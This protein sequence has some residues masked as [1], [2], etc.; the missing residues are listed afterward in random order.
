MFKYDEP[1][2]RRPDTPGR[3]RPAATTPAF[4]LTYLIRLLLRRAVWIIG[5]ALACAVIAV[6]IGKS[7]TP[8]FAATTQL[9]IDPREL[10]LV[11]RELTPR[12]Q[13]LSG[14]TMV[15][16]S[17][18]RLM[19]SS[20]VLRKV[21]DDMKLRDDPEFG[22]G[23][24]L[25]FLSRL[26]GSNT[27]ARTLEIDEQAA[28]I[29]ALRRHIA[30]KRTDR[31]FIVDIEV[32]SRDATK[33]ALLA[34]AVAD[35]Y[36]I[37]SKESQAA[38]ARRATIDLSGRLKELQ[39]RL[40][41][42]ENNLAVYKS[43]N[44]FI[45]SQ[46][47]QVSDQQLLSGAQRLANA[48]AALLDAKARYSQIEASRKNA[49]D[50]GAIPEAMMSPTIAN[51]RTQFAE[52]RRKQAELIGELGPLH[53]A[54]R[55][56]N[57]Q[58]DDLRVNIGEELA[59]FAQLAKNDITRAQDL[60]TSLTKALDAQKRQSS[61]L[62]QAS[63]E[64]RELEREVE[65][66]RAIYQ[67]FLK[68]SRET[69]EQE[70]LNT[71]NARIIGAATTPQR[72]IFPPPMSLLA[73]IG[74]TL[75]ALGAMACI[76]LLDRFAW[77]LAPLPTMGPPRGPD[78]GRKAKAEPVSVVQAPPSQPKPQPL[79]QHQPRPMPAPV[80]QLCEPVYVRLQE[81]DVLR[82]LN[83]IFPLSGG[84]DIVRLGW[85][86][87]LTGPAS[88]RFADASLRMVRLAAGH[89][90]NGPV[91]I[92]ATGPGRDDRT[93]VA[94]NVALAATRTGWRVLLIDADRSAQAI[95]KRLN[96]RVGRSGMP[97]GERAHMPAVDEMS[98]VAIQRLDLVR[99]EDA[100]L[101]ALAAA[102]RSGL[103]DLIVLDG[104][105]GP[106]GAADRRLLDAIDG[107]FVVV[108]DRVPPKDYVQA[109]T[110]GLDGG[111]Q[112]LVG[113]VFSELGAQQAPAAQ[114][115]YA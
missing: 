101:D 97:G 86:T 59:R 24:T 40:R 10:Q 57:K 19:T 26:F 44:N 60:E 15:A 32:W 98:G 114:R 21:V 41:V 102:R 13:D 108:P 50:P 107:V 30:V 53:P 45:G 34:N 3:D 28:A 99:F 16:E 72:R 22:G 14:L 77:L 54:L 62:G 96:S 70:S 31:T 94:L 58:V 83:G 95:S 35:A 105:N 82:T 6:V 51:L 113:V 91:A 110:S 87:L 27:D 37:E 112:K 47:T 92:A 84:P 109:A 9:Y 48:Q 103:Y 106:A 1:V 23:A 89:S 88:Q 56:A 85:P 111:A 8:K 93:I 69:E 49:T 7:L 38:A 33:A 52:A 39:E 20:S 66:S 78:G 43:R 55:M 42:A 81:A 36:M 61:D 17:Q 18:V 79:P 90:Q 73:M 25:G 100:A 2:D 29:D 80:A 65:A 11:E 68:R 67:S 4:D 115:Q 64:L 5:A 76:I 75:G 104:P 71:S 46:D 74:F 63:V 12:S